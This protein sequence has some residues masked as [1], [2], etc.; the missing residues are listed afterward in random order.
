M[1]W[2][3]RASLFASTKVEVPISKSDKIVHLKLLL[4]AKATEVECYKIYA[5]WQSLANTLRK[6]DAIVNAHMHN[7]EEIIAFA[8]TITSFIEVFTTL[9][10][11][12]N[13]SNTLTIRYVWASYYLTFVKKVLH[14]FVRSIEQVLP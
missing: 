2:M 8:W 11:I 5:A 12:H 7:D 6:L 4:S 3:G 1:A 14:L 13:L 9:E 10:F